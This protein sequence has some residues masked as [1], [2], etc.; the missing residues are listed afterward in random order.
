MHRTLKWIIAAALVLC[1]GT[2]A[3]ASAEGSYY[4]ELPAM[5][6]TSSRNITVNVPA[7]NPVIEGIN[8]IN[9]ET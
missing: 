4:L 1:L 8:P 5:G 7:E 2:A 9:G 6:I 3:V